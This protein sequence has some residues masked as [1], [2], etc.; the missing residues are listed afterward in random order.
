MAVRGLPRFVK[1]LLAAPGIDVNPPNKK[2][3]IPLS[4]AA[5]WSNSECL[6]LLLKVK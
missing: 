3:Q 5:S 4:G 2:G 1:L 6:K